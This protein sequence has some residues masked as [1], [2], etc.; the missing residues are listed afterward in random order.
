MDHK[1]K[2][3]HQ[4]LPASIPTPS[5]IYNHQASETFDG[6]LTRDWCSASSVLSIRIH[7]LRWGCLW[8]GHCPSAWPHRASHC[9]RD[10]SP[11]A[12]CF[13]LPFAYP[14]WLIC[15]VCHKRKQTRAF[16]S[17]RWSLCL[18]WKSFFHAF[19][20]PSCWWSPW[21]SKSEQV[22][23]SLHCYVHYPPF[24]PWS[25]MKKNDQIRSNQRTLCFPCRS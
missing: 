18:N 25:R 12:C 2:R 17:A 1:Y 3:C 24:L 14:R 22:Q 5:L 21:L 7:N 8:W 6:P 15:S 16:G 13:L 9:P 11:T 4:L 20:H 19:C 23:Q 10:Q